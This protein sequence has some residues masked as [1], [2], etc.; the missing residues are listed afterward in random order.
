MNTKPEY[1][2]PTVEQLGTFEEMTKA[3][4]TGPLSDANLGQ[5]V[6]GGGRYS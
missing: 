4:S 3:S 5:P 2:A 1:K 6:I